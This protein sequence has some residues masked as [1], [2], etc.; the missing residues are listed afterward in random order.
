[1]KREFPRNRIKTR[2]AVKGCGKLEGNL[3]KTKGVAVE[4]VWNTWGKPSFV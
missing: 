4:K 3:W 1:M 2:P